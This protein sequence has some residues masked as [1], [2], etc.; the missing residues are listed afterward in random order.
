MG[1]TSKSGQAAWQRTHRIGLL[2]ETDVDE[3]VVLNGWVAKRRNMGGIYFLDMRDRFG[4]SQVVLTGSEERIGWSMDEG[5][6]LAP[7]DVLS[8]VG[9]VK[10]REQPNDEMPTGQIEVIAE[11]VEVLSRS[12][13]A[14]FEIERDSDA[15]VE[16][17][18]RHRYLDL[19]RPDMQEKMIFR[20]KF[21]GAMRNAFL[22]REFL[23][24]ETPMLTRATP[25]GARDYLVPS[26]VHAGKFYALPQSPQI[27]KQI[28][29]VSGMDSY[30][31]VARCFRDEDLRADRQPEF[32]QLDMEMSFV[33]EEDIYAVWEGIVGDT[34]REAMDLELPSTFARLTWIE[35]MER[36]G[37]DKPDT[38]F[39]L[40]LQNL[41]DWAKDCGFGVFEK[42]VAG[43]DRVMAISMPNGAEH[44]SRGAM[45]ALEKLA[46]ENGAFGLA[47]WKPG[48]TGGAAGPVAKFM[49]GDPGARLLQT[50]GAKE[51]DL[52]LFSAGS[53]EL[54][55]RVLG[56]LRLHLAKATNLIEA[57]KWNFLW[58][59]EFPM[60]EWSEEDQRYT[61]SHHPFTAPE[62]WDMAGNP[63]HMASRAYDLVLNGWELGSGSVRIHRADVQQKV[64]ELLGIRE[65][66]QKAK[67]GFLLEALAHGAPPHAGFAIGLDRLVALCLGLDSIRDVVAFPKTLQATDL[68]C[69]APSTVEAQSLKDI[70]ISLESEV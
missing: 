2:R 19:R 41:G 37:S 12:R 52:V 23:E 32:T 67:F 4:V 13:L 30:F 51:G 27:F 34:F 18:L 40:E 22:E 28:L 69:E 57:G 43:G 44:F 35:A 60:F 8:V 70:H 39:E 1:S 26:R 42:A 5:E 66:E 65:E 7:E 6:I 11:R 3:K 50:L 16:L 49:D 68:M 20:S 17:R 25:E 45:K 54:C 46:K 38:R 31:Q 21:V 15:N 24:I 63:A 55:W 48:L 53:K 29:M 33:E 10:K 64:F 61:S 9:T 47:W 14:P 36:Y 62:S 58:V 56:E 59:T